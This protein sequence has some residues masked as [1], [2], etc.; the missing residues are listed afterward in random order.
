ML[1]TTEPLF[2][3]YLTYSQNKTRVLVDLFN[4]HNNNWQTI[5]L[6]IYTLYRDWSLS[7]LQ[8]L[9]A[10]NLCLIQQ[11]FILQIN[12]VLF[13][14]LLTTSFLIV[15]LT[16]F[17]KITMTKTS[18][19]NFDKKDQTKYMYLFMAFISLLFSWSKINSHAI[20]K[21]STNPKLNKVK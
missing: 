6:K 16:L 9:R 5:H 12:H 15:V 19:R 18:A 21:M 11:V 1:N 13:L 7:S 2:N 10:E 8:K 17:L 3:L 14:G 20:I 4:Y